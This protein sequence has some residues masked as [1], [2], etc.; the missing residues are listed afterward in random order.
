MQRILLLLLILA[1]IPGCTKKLDEKPSSSL[2]LPE[3]IQDFENMLD[4][5][6]L[7]N[8]TT[9]LPQ[10]SADEYYIPTLANFNALANPISKNTYIWQKNIFEGRTQIRDWSE[11]YAQVF[12]CNSV[13]DKIAKK[14]VANDAEWKRIKGWALFG[15][16]YAFYT[17]VS[18]FSKA[19]DA[20][21]AG[22]DLGIPLKLTSG[23]TEIMPRSSV[24]QTYDQ[25]IK[26]ALDASELLQQDIPATK[27]NRPSKIAAYSFLAR[28]T[29][30]MRKYADAEL[31]TDKALA[32]YSKL[33]DYNTL[34]VSPTVSSW[35][36][37]NS[38]E[39]IYFTRNENSQYSPTT[40]SSGALYGVDTNLRKEYH[41]N[42]LRRTVYFRINA[43]G[44][45]AVSKGIYA[46]VGYPFTGLATDELYMIKAECAAR[47][48]RTTEAMTV[49]NNL[50][51][52]RYKT[53]TY[54]DLTASSATDAL[55]KVLYERKKELIWRCVRW[56]D[57]KRLN[58]EGRNIVLTRNLDGQIYTLPPNSPLYVL[59][60]P[61]DEVALSGIQ[62]NIR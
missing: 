45:W 54:T 3:S 18:T 7:M 1:T 34:P 23:I 41:T 51:R 21:T 46:P 24:Q 47:A 12:I 50:L 15:R 30:S 20:A 17:L 19:Y 11:P 52:T 29:L 22:T 9:A 35:S 13:L 8:L 2:V 6:Q 26:D 14:D 5:T 62:Q 27:R 28:V 10:M 56:T 32:L 53:G 25:I 60:I 16:A 43:N 31:Y 37:R 57:L 36:D 40:Y 33:T 59:P 38:E 4:N 42:D 55:D 49:L 61:D 39:L 58:L 48:N 44:N